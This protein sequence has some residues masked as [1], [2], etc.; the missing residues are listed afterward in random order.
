MVRRN[1]SDAADI[2]TGARNRIENGLTTRPSKTASGE[3]E[4]VEAENIGRL[5]SSRRWLTGSA[6]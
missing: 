3:L 5:T 1:G 4:N 6:I 2:I